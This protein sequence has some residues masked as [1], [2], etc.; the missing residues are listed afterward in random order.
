MYPTNTQLPFK[1]RWYQAQILPRCTEQMTVFHLWIGLIKQQSAPHPD[2]VLHCGS[3]NST[4]IEEKRCLFNQLQ[5]SWPFT[6]Y[7][8]RLTHPHPALTHSDLAIYKSI[9]SEHKQHN[10]GASLGVTGILYTKVVKSTGGVELLD[11]MT[12]FNEKSE[13]SVDICFISLLWVFQEEKKY[14]IKREVC[15][16]KQAEWKVLVLMKQDLF[17]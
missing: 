4:K 7:P 17:V 1:W 3:Q 13:I 9:I 5:G 14:K 8:A 15:E 2:P 6:E 12:E 11:S 10:R 16:W